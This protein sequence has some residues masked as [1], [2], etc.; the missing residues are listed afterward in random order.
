MANGAFVQFDQV[1]ADTYHYAVTDCCRES[2]MLP[3]RILI[4]LLSL[5]PAVCR[6]EG[7]PPVVQEHCVR[8]HGAD[9]LATAPGMPHLNGQL[10][11]YLSDAL[12]KF[13]KGRLPS[14]VVNHVPASLGAVEIGQVAEYYAVVKAE[15]PKQEISP[16][17]VALGA[18][19]YR[20]RCLDCHDD[21]GREA[22]KGA[23]L[24]A[25]QNLDYLIAQTR[26]FVSGKRKFGFLQDDA[27]KGLSG[28]ELEAV[29]HYFAAQ[30]QI[31]P[32]VA[33]KKKRR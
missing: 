18:E 2:A 6:A 15:R 14:G 5:M 17:K 25:A 10:A 3:K 21:N 26:L 1:G 20:N 13:Q 4:C 22:D 31:A 29:A 32:K 8:C 33:G 12:V 30:D 9:G 16:D 7:I 28:D 19:I 23:P 27:F 24:L 11:G